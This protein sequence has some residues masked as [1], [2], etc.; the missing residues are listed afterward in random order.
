M[1]TKMGEEVEGG[2]EEYSHLYGEQPDKTLV[3]H[4]KGCSSTHG[5]PSLQYPVQNQRFFIA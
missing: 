3:H 4:P 1:T 5:F 2:G